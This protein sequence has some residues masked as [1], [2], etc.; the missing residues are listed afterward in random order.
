MRRVKLLGLALMAVFAFGVVIAATAS[1]EEKEPAGLLFLPKEEGPVT[2][3]G[4]GG[5]VKLSSAG[6][7][8]VTITCTK[9]KTEGTSNAGEKL[10]ITL[11]TLTIDY[12]GC[13]LNNKINCSSENIKGEKDPA[14]TILQISVDTDLH[15]V[16]LESGGKLV[17]GV[18]IGLLELVEGAKKL[19]LTLNCGGVKVLILGAVFLEAAGGSATEEVKEV[20]IK[21]TP[22][23][24]DEKDKLCKEE[25]AKWGATATEKVGEKDEKVLCPLALFV[26]VEEE[27]GKLSI[28]VAI[29]TKLST[30]V[31]WDF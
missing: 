27:C 22:L 25:L 18:I 30:D 1:A 11:A 3:K 24:C 10:H 14:K 4:E 29:P 16:S 7:L 17:K 31:L 21:D 5:E 9:V 19:D 26:E 15:F 13:T 23:K 12:E 6:L 28:P 2:L 8:K 20:K